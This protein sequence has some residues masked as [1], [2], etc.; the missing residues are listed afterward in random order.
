[1]KIGIIGPP[2]SGKSTIFKILL[3]KDAPGNV[4]IFKVLDH[5]VEKISEIFS[6][7]KTAYPEFTFLDLG[8]LM[9][10]N[11]RDLVQLQDM[12]LFICAIGAFFSKDL[13]K[14]FESYITDIILLDLEVIQNRI[15]RLKKEGRT[16]NSNIEQEL[17]VLEKCQGVLSEGKVLR[18]A[19]LDVNEIRSFSG[20]VLLTLKPLIA[21]INISEKDVEFSDS[22]VKLLE[23]YCQSRDICHIRF[24]GKTELELLELGAEERKNFLVELGPGYNFREDVSKWIPRELSLI[25]FFTTGEKETR[26]WYLKSGSSAIEAAGKVHSDM[27]RGF[28]RAEVVN[29]EDFSKCG[30][31]HKA[32][33]KGLLKVEGRDYIVKDGDIINVRFNV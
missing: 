17:K 32:R 27:K 11:K 2:Q 22:S 18:K 6:S 33:E 25:T 8:S 30:S 5:R 3:H 19:G 23:E 10:F 14:D 12:D 9:D 31:I 16:P 20:L 15:A 29:Y 28:I 1:M 7:K 26:G 21:A 24:Y 13:K 4:G